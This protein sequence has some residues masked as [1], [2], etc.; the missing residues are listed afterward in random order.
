MDTLFNTGLRAGFA[1][2]EGLPNVWQVNHSAAKQ[3]NIRSFGQITE[4]GML[5]NI[6]HRSN[7]IR[8]PSGT[9]V[10]QSAYGPRITVYN[11]LIIPFPQ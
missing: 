7:L 10:F 5:L 4:R 1:N 2:T 11:A 3:L 6:F 9:G 8:L